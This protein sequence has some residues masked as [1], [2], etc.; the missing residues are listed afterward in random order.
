MRRL[1]TVVCIAVVLVAASSTHGIDIEGT[2]VVIPVAM[3]GPGALGTQWRTDVWISNMTTAAKNVTITFY[4]TNG[5][6]G[7]TT[8]NVPR[9]GTVELRDVVLSTFGFANAKGLLMLS[10]ESATGFQA[11]ARIYNAGNPMGEFGQFVPG[12]A[13]ARLERQAYVAGLAGVDGN[14]ANFGIAN[15]SD[16]S[17]DVEVY[18]LDGQGNL[19]DTQDF[20][21]GG[22]SVV[23]VNDM[24]AEFDITPRRE[25]QLDM[26]A[27]APVPIYGYASVVRN[28]T[29]DAIFIFGTSPNN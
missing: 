14:R 19:L 1:K 23:Q 20:T 8:V 6:P 15:P 13:T 12:I 9:A 11:T 28:D 4:R 27:A 2:T 18:V 25:V 5:E 16:E 22:M 26:H 29:G 21:V 3:H 24:F 10:V 17:I 7:V